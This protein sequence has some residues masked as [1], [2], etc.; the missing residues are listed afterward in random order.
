MKEQRFKSFFLSLLFCF[1]GILLPLQAFAQTK[2]AYGVLS[3]DG[4]TFTFRYDEY[5]TD[6]AR[7]F[8]E[9][10][11]SS[12]K[13]VIFEPSFKDYHPT[14]TAGLFYLC[15]NLKEIDGI[16]YLNTEQVTDMNG[17]FSRCNS[18]T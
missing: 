1:M 5:K 16:E 8:E 10:V 9:G 3:G 7:P 14:S 4:K 6:G 12:V 13:K 15:Y 2:E 18:L 11:P 17:M